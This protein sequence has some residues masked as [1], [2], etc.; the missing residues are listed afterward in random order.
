MTR[1]PP[2]WYNKHIRGNMLS[3]A[4]IEDHPSYKL[5]YDKD[6]KRFIVMDKVSNKTFHFTQKSGGKL[7][8][9]TPMMEATHINTIKDMRKQFM[10]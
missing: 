8:I 2:V 3:F 1:L 7:Y 6:N 9:Y 10:P 4:K 5:D